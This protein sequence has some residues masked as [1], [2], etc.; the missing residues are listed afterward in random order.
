MIRPTVSFSMIGYVTST[1]IAAFMRI[2]IVELLES[3]LYSLYSSLG[4]GVGEVVGP[5]VMEGDIM[6]EGDVV[7]EGEGDGIEVVGDVVAEGDTV[8]VGDAVTDGVEVRSADAAVKV[9]V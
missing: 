2:H 1:D 7:T 3:F 9:H 5:T 8:V 4:R 6:V